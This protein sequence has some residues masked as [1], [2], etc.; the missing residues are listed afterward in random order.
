MEE[1]VNEEAMIMWKRWRD[2]EEWHI[3]N[4]QY[5]YSY[6]RWSVAGEKQLTHDF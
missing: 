6:E 3:H 4:V 1:V 2:G 5:M